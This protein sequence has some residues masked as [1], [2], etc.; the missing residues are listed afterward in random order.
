LAA[1]LTRQFHYLHSE[2]NEA[3]SIPE[4]IQQKKRAATTCRN[5]SRLVFLMLKEQCSVRKIEIQGFG[6]A[7]FFYK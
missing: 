5:S 1:E 2:I 3:L 7:V 4:I 6:A